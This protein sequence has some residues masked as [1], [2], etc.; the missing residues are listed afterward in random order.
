MYSLKEKG[1]GGGGLYKLKSQKG[2]MSI[3]TRSSFSSLVFVLP[4]INLENFTDV[5]FIGTK[6]CFNSFVT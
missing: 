5:I 2:I 3:S 4:L 6:V 1:G